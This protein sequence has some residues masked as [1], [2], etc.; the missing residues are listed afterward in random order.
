[1]SYLKFDKTQL[2][3]LN[4]SLKREFLRTNRAGSFCT[5]T[6]INCNTRKYHGL[7]IVPMYELDKGSH[8]LLSSLD[9]TV[10]QHNKEF[11]LAV[12][13]YPGVIHPG[14]KYVKEFSSEPIPTI[15][16]QV[17][18]V[19]LKKEMLLVE[20]QAQ[21]LVKYTMMDCHSET[22]IRLHPFLV[23][24]NIH[25]LAKANDSVDK[26]FES[27]NKGISLRMYDVYPKLHLQLS[28]ETEYVPCPDWFYNV[29][30]TE[31]KERGY[32]STEDLYV[33]GFFEFN[34]KK[35]EEIIF[36]ASLKDVDPKSF[37]TKF[38]S[39]LKK[40]TP[41]NN[42]E[43]C[44]INA[45]QQFV[46]RR[47]DATEITT[48][49]PW[50]AR[51]RRETLISLPGLTLSTGDTKTCKEVLTNMA[52]RLSQ[53]I[54]YETGRDNY[55]SDVPLWF[56][57][58]VQKY[59]EHI[60][61]PAKI[62]KEFGE[63][64]KKIISAY[65]DSGV[66]NIKVQS[67]G[68]IY[69]G[70]RGSALTWMDAFVNS[71]AV[72][73]RIGY[74]V[75]VNALWYNAVSFILELASK[76]KDKAFVDTYSY[77][78][79]QIKSAFVETFWDGSKKYLA[80]Y[81]DGNFKDWSIRPNQIFAASLPYSPLSDEAKND[82]VETVRRELLTPRGLRTLTPSHSEYRPSCE[83]DVVSRDLAIHQGTAHPW[84]LGAFA[85]AYLKLH[86]NSGVS[87]IKK[88]YLGFEDEM[89]KDGISSIS[90]LYDGNPPHE[91]R[92][93]ISHSCSV[94]EL[95]RIKAMIDAY[96]S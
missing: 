70:L 93:A 46:V 51:W 54:F 39:E 96:E 71:T 41:R 42:F 4:Y 89:S 12:H 66:F 47:E 29:E 90:E 65:F 26:T 27:I 72:T 68:L 63:L 69:A 52:D 40:R 19:V 22:V 83:G 17:A 24:R 28:K 73:P 81:V 15:I 62:W 58:S 32:D 67:N 8:V 78:P 34:M 88:L 11:H 44:L 25:A 23:F 7:L 48:C 20:D 9:E 84:L 16:Y 57:W 43:N 35:G 36:S 55:A 5:S 18:G 50:A 59:A 80:D 30:Y 61:Q 75:E 3:N 21:L 82:I 6:I 53:S 38:N 87:F 94:G 13:K 2:V 45:A 14:H 91:G 79:D 31:E 64:F 77:L 1:M 10:I 37:N 60:K 86:E 33:N 76:A 95:L 85:E 56:V 92:G 74:T 49:Y